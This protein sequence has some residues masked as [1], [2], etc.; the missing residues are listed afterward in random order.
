[1]IK[2]VRNL[3]IGNWVRGSDSVVPQPILML[4]QYGDSVLINKL[5]ANHYEGIPITEEI[6]ESAGFEFYEYELVDGQELPDVYTIGEEGQEILFSWYRKFKN[7]LVYYGIEIH[8]SGRHCFFKTHHYQ[9]RTDRDNDMDM[10]VIGY[11]EY[12]HEL[13]NMFFQCFE[14]EIEIVF[15]NK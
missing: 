15:K 12:V 7:E 14:E 10:S 1:M 4:E 9:H 3:R 2:N 13:Q 5:T 11:V 8:P 6:I